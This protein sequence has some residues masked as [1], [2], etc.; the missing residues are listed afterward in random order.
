[1]NRQWKINRDFFYADLY[2]G[3]G[4]D[5]IEEAG[6]FYDTDLIDRDIKGSLDLLCT[7]LGFENE[8]TEKSCV[9]LTT[10]SFC[11]IHYGHIEMM[12][13]ARQELTKQ[14]W[15]VLRGYIAPAHDE[16]IKRKCGA[17]WINIDRR[18]QIIQ[19]E[20]TESDWL[21]LDPWEGVFNSVAVNFTDVIFRLSAYIKKHLNTNIPVFYVCGSDNAR[22]AKTFLIKGHCVVVKRPGYENQ[23]ANY[24][25]LSSDRI[26]FID[27]NA[28]VSSSELG[29][30]SRLGLKKSSLDLITQGHP[31]EE[32]LVKILSLYYSNIHLHRLEKFRVENHKSLPSIALDNAIECDYSLSISRLYQLGGS[33]FKEFVPRPGSKPISDQ[34]NLIPEDEY[35]LWDTDSYSGKTF[36]FI[37]QLLQQH[38]IQPIKMNTLLVPSQSEILDARD[39]FLDAPD[40][41]LVVQLPNGEITRA[42]YIY[43]YVNPAVRCSLENAL[44][45]SI[46]IWKLNRDYFHQ[47]KACLQQLTTNKFLFLYQ[48]F[49]AQDSLADIADWHYQK[50]SDYSAHA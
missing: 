19:K 28:R 6:F 50:L 37:K 38:N 36:G 48:G 12:E 1:M 46:A 24:Q 33:L 18:I 29:H 16:Y 45:F 9:L 10:G 14:G 7:P 25:H 49:S 41:G 30:K 40:A 32:E 47:R 2:E 3:H 5:F 42:P 39:F 15:N 8:L 27:G 21:A 11:P 44:E 4:F 22:F 26:L 20:I 17:D 13:R 34:L 43:P 35:Q 23:F 31:L